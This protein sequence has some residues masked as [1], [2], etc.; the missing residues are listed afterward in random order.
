LEHAWKFSLDL[1]KL[2]YFYKINLSIMDILA[3]P[4]KKVKILLS[5]IKGP[6]DLPFVK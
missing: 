3:L 2:D 1:H 6:W 5:V 4:I